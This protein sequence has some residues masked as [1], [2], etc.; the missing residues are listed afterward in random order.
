MPLIFEDSVSEQF[1]SSELG[2]WFG[3]AHRLS[4]ILNNREYLSNNKKGK[5]HF[6]KEGNFSDNFLR[7]YRNL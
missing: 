7:F 4:E 1:I 3:D 2:I 5:N 6:W